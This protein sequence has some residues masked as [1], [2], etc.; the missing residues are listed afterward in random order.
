MIKIF[1]DGRIAHEGCEISESEKGKYIEVD[2]LPVA[3]YVRGK[4][5]YCAANLIT[6]SIEFRY[7]ED[8]SIIDD[9]ATE[10]PPLSALEQNT[11]EIALNTEYLICL[12]E[13][14]M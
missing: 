12:A 4:L 11:L 14:D 1:D 2:K 6:N 9:E 10:E 8:A 3:P 5:G 13:L 7:T